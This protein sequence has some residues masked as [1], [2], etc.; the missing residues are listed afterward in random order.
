MSVSLRVDVI[1]HATFS[2]VLDG[3]YPSRT[4]RGTPSG[5]GGV[6][7]D[8]YHCQIS[9]SNWVGFQVVFRVVSKAFGLTDSTGGVVFGVPSLGF[10]QT[11]P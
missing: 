3:P 11:W 2:V 9:G 5:G 7:Q 6:A 10:E 1:P 8:N 4:L